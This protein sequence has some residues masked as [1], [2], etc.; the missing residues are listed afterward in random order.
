VRGKRYVGEDVKRYTELLLAAA[1][2]D[3]G[4]CANH[5]RARCARDLDRLA[6]RATGRHH[7]LDHQH[8]FACLERETTPHREPTVLTLS[9]HRADPERTSDLLADHDATQCGRQHNLCAE[10]ANLF[11]DADA[12]RFRLGRVLEHKRA[13]QKP[14]AVKTGCQAEV[15]F[16]KGS[17]SSKS[18]EYRRRSFGRHKNRLVY[19]GV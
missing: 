10:A 16:E 11:G 18:V 5:L 13:L 4:G 2:I 1:P 14:G 15:P 9:K 17:D 19:I 7:I 12:A 8:L 6:R 3:N